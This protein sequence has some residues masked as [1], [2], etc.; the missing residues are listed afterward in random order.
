MD[1]GG[2]GQSDV[3]CGVRLGAN[4]SDVCVCDGGGGV[5]CGGEVVL[6]VE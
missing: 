2:G 5:V 6:L 3:G 4:D 1:D